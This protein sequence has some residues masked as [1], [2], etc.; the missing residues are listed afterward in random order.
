MRSESRSVASGVVDRLRLWHRLEHDVDWIGYEGWRRILPERVVRL[1]AH[2]DV[3]ALL[4][5]VMLGDGHPLLLRHHRQDTG[6]SAGLAL[7]GA[8][9]GAWR[10]GFEVQCLELL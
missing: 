10:V 7:G 9:L 2:D 6:R 8:D 5:V 3:D 1:R 4:Q